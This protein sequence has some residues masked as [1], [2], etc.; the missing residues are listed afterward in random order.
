MGFI[1][2]L[3]IQMAEMRALL[4]RLLDENNDESACKI[5]ERASSR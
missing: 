4:Q 3:E 2:K 5:Q 1:E